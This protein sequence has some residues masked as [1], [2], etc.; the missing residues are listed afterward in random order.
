MAHKSFSLFVAVCGVTISD[1]L[2][3]WDEAS[4]ILI[5]FMI[6]DYSTGVLKAIRAKSVTSEVMFW[7]GIKKLSML[8]VVMV[9]VLL[10][11]FMGNQT[12]L[13]RTA[14]IYY[15]VGMEGLSLV[16]NLGAL[17]VPLPSFL[18]SILSQVKEKGTIK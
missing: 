5:T 8:V 17:G 13:F 9:A 10:D 14:A 16:E 11:H 6:L 18:V 15:Y 7:G 12:P 4:K 3:G 1:W 2:G